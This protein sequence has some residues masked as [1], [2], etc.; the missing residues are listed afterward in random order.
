MKT[1]LYRTVAIAALV[2]PSMAFAQS[3]GSSDFEEETIVVTGTRNQEV[4]GVKI[5]DSPKAKVVIGEELIQAQRP[6]QSINEIINL[7]PG[8]SFTNNDPWGSSGGSF[9]IRGF[10]SDRISQTFDGIPLNDSGNYAIYTNQQVDPELVQ[11]I[12]V[13]LGSTDV[14]SPTAAA[15]GGT[16]NINT[17]V[18]SDEMGALMSATYGNIIAKGSGDRPMY[19]VFGVINTGVFTPFGTKAWFS[20]SNTSN[21]AAFANY[22]KVRKQQYN[23]K[24]YQPI[25]D[26]GDFISIAGHY[27]EN[28]NNFGGSPLRASAITGDK[29]GRFYDI[30][31]GYPCSVSLNGTPNSC[32]T[33]FERRYNPSNTGNVRWQSRFGLTDSLTFSFDG[34]YQ[35]VKANG[36]GT[37][38]ANEGFNYIGGK[39]FTGNY[40]GSFY[41]GEDLNGDGNLGTDI[42]GD[43]IIANYQVTNANGSRTTVYESDRMTVL[44][45]SQT[46]TR[47]WV[48]IANLAYEI[49]DTNRV[50]LSYSFDRARHRQTGAAGLLF[51][52]GEPQDV[53]AINNPILDSAGNILQ[54]RD[55]K[56][57]ATL[58][59]IAGEY[60]GD[61]FEDKLTV[62]LGA[63]M[64]FFK[65]ELNQYCFTTNT[66]GGS[67]AFVNCVPEDQQADYIKA[68]PYSY[69]EKTGRATGAA[70]PQSRNLKYDKFLPN[71]GVVYKITPQISV[72][73]SYSK[74]IS[75]PST[76]ALYNAFYYPAGS[77][78]AHRVAETSD[79][80]DGSLRYT[81]SKIQAAV[82]GWYSKYK[83][84]LVTAYDIDGFGT[85]T[86]L[87]PVKKYGIDGSISYSPVKAI[88]GYVFGSYIKSEIQND[89]ITG[90]CSATSDIALAGLCYSET[91]GTGAN[92]VTTHYLRTA[93]KRERSAPKYLF[94]GRLQGELGDLRLG[95][96]AK[97]TSSRYMN[98]INGEVETIT[99]PDNTTKLI[100]PGAKFKAYTVVDLDLRYSL[101]GAGLEKGA[102]QL[103]ISNLFDKY[104]VGSFSGGL[105]TLASS[106]SAFVN[107]GSPRA[108][109]AS[110]IV[111]F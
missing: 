96:Q 64:P 100:A 65:R 59:Q 38:S 33:D 31:G 36:G 62:L 40:G 111:G 15:V 71:L 63:R 41:F 84:R 43:G 48:A 10:S 102:I 57:Y 107:F 35:S 56:S 70:I 27:N 109:S 39:P 82:T 50:R 80:F 18:P 88:T 12:N 76:D 74:N 94:G 44:Q 90:S 81:S 22:G 52:N 1:M 55:R 45:P 25:G 87:G 85:D 9:T 99:L 17:L 91:V 54:K 20:A 7:V 32:G 6:G 8:V 101:A 14:D 5:P 26:N 29:K 103:N 75:V 66:G 67:G 97:R 21:V 30:S 72:A 24:I 61:F 37:T 68:N 78:A 73:T 93:G 108:I 42:N 47:R 106:T 13:N 16:V 2:M 23:A 58:H 3:T 4:G 89:T 19:R 86:N 34:A 92:A 60:R 79:S 51:E 104:Y 83:N 105:D 69:D 77:D 98:D 11:T 53:F 46:N 49:N 110:F 95:V 28:R